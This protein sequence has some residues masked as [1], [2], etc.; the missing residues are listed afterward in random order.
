VA[1][2]TAPAPVPGTAPGPVG[3]RVAL[4]PV[5]PVAPA[6]LGAWV[7][8]SVVWASVVLV[9]VRVVPARAESDSAPAG[10]ECSRI[11]PSLGSMLPTIVARGLAHCQPG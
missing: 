7:W 2:S 1:P 5:A 10:M 6:V 3:V 11:L 9:V 8:A 4:A